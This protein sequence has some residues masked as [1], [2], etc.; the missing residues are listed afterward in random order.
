MRVIFW[1]SDNGQNPKDSI[2][3]FNHS[4]P[5]AS[6]AFH[7]LAIIIGLRHLAI[8]LP[9]DIGEASRRLGVSILAFLLHNFSNNIVVNKYILNF[10]YYISILFI[11]IV[12]LVL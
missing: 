8:E 5:F 3:L 2:L 10:Q 11:Y 7:N 12:L 1:I 4:V 6:A 9:T